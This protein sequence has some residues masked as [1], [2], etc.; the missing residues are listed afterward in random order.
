MIRRLL[1]AIA[2]LA[3]A[4]ATYQAAFAQSVL[5]PGDITCALDPKCAKP[6]PPRTRSWQPQ[7]RGVIVEGTPEEQPLSVNIY[8]NFAYNSAELTSDAR[9]TLDG[10]GTAL[11]D[12]RLAGFN[13]LIAGHTDARGGDEFNQKLSERRAD[14]V[15]D[16]IV[17]KFQIAPERLATRGYGKTQL[18]DPTRP[19]DGVNRRVQ[20]INATAGSKHN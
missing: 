2:I 20:V 14:A 9:I 10:L 6:Q 7:Q 18:L 16:Y 11:S 13:F 8:V 17:A 5:S 4:P 15:R 19:E 12:P 3:V 1:L